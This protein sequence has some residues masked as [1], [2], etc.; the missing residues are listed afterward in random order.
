MASING[1]D[2]VGYPVTLVGA[3]AVVRTAHL[4]EKHAG[5]SKSDTRKITHTGV[6]KGDGGNQ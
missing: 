1:N 3:L 5:L 4:L 2:W 6:L